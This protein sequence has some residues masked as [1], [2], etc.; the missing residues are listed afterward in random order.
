[1][2]GAKR[3]PHAVSDAGGT[4]ALLPEHGQDDRRWHANPD[5][6]QGQALRVV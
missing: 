3:R 4:L 1:V 2:D 5:A 6:T